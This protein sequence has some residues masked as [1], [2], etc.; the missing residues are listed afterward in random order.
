MNRPAAATPSFPQYSQAERRLDLGVHILGLALAAVGA[1]SLLILGIPRADAGDAAGLA[2]YATGLVAMLAFSCAYHLSGQACRKEMLRRFDRAAIFIMIAGTY[3]PF[4][5]GRLAG[6]SGIALFASVWLLALVGASLAFA[7]PRRGDRMALVLY[8]AM[9]WCVLAVIGPL[10]DAVP[11]RVIALLLVGGV[12]YTAGVAL[13]LAR[14]LPYHN[15][16]WHACVLVAA[17]CHFFAVLG[18]FGAAPA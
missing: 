7:M 10:A 15:A 4:A 16:L 12:V 9:G 8:L 6:A 18:T 5:L 1:P 11:R 2:L 3:S 13:H 17:S 14:R